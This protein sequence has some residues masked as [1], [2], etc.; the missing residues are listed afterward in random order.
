[1][2]GGFDGYRNIEWRDHNAARN[3]P[4]DVTATRTS[5]DSLFMLAN[6]VLIGMYV[7]IPVERDVLISNFFLKE[8]SNLPGALKLTIGYQPPSGT[9]FVVAAV[10]V[11]KATFE[12]GKTYKMVPV[13]AWS[14]ISVHVVID[15]LPDDTAPSGVFEFDLDGG[16]L[17]TDIIRPSLSHLHGIEVVQ[18]DGSAQLLT[19]I[20]QLKPGTNVRLDASEISTG[21]YEL[22][23]HAIDGEGLS[24][25]CE[26]G[27]VLSDPIRTI[28]KISGDS[29]GNI[30]IVGSKCLT[31][32]PR[33]AFIAMSNPC[34]EPCC[35]CEEA[36]ALTQAL[37]PLSHRTTSVQSSIA[38]L[39]V[40]TDKLNALVDIYNLA[41]SCPAP[42]LPANSTTLPPG[43]TIQCG[44]N[45][46]FSGGVEY[47][48]QLTVDLGTDIGSVLVKLDAYS[49]P[50]LV[51]VKWNGAVVL[52]TG[53]H[54]STVYDFG[55]A[56]RA[57]FT[58]ALIG[59][60]DP[61]YGTTF[62]D[63][64]NYPDD[65]YPRII[66]PT[67]GVSFDKTLAQP[68]TATI[69][70]YAPMTGTLW[71][72]VANCP[73]PSGT[74]TSTTTTA[75]PESLPPFT[76]HV[77]AFNA[78]WQLSPDGSKTYLSMT[79]CDV[80]SLAFDAINSRYYAVYSP[81]ASPN[82]VRVRVL[83]I[84]GRVGDTNQ[85]LYATL[86]D[87][88]LSPTLLKAS[89]AYSSVSQKAY[90]VS[91]GAIVSVKSDYTGVDA[92]YTPTNHIHGGGVVNSLVSVH[93]DR[94]VFV[95]GLSNATQGT[96]YVVDL[97]GA[98]FTVA[99]T[100][101]YTD[102]PVG[103]NFT[104]TVAGLSF[105]EPGGFYAVWDNA[106]PPPGQHVRRKPTN[107]PPGTI[108]GFLSAVMRPV[109]PNIYIA[110]GCNSV[111][112][113]IES[114]QFGTNNYYQ[115]YD[116]FDGGWFSVNF[117]T[118]PS[119]PSMSFTTTT[120]TTAAPTT[121]PAPTT[122]TVAPT[123]TPP[124]G[125]TTTTAAPTTTATP[126]TTTTAAPTTTEPPEPSIQSL[127]ANLIVGGEA[128]VGVFFVGGDKAFMDTEIGEVSERVAFNNNTMRMYVESVHA[129]TAD[130]TIRAYTVTS[131]T[132][133]GLINRTV[134]DDL[135]DPIS[136]T[137]F[138]NLLYSDTA[139]KVMHIRKDRI[140]ELDEVVGTVAF[141]DTLLTMPGGWEIE[142]AGVT[143]Y[144]HTHLL[145]VINDPA[146][147]NSRR[148]VSL[149]VT[150]PLPWEFADFTVLDA[151]APAGIK[152]L[153]GSTSV[154]YYG[155][156]ANITPVNR[157]NY[158]GT[159]RS[160]KSGIKYT[161]VD[162]GPVSGTPYIGSASYMGTSSQVQGFYGTWP[163]GIYR[164]RANVTD[165][166][167]LSLW[168]T[169]VAH[170]TVDANNDL[171][172]LTSTT[173]TLPPPAPLPNV[174]HYV[175]N[176]LVMTFYPATNSIAYFNTTIDVHEKIAVDTANGRVYTMARRAG[177]TDRYIRVFNVGS[178]TA[179]VNTYLATLSH[180]VY[181][182]VLEPA[183]RA[184]IITLEFSTVTGKAY[185]IYKTGVVPI[186]L[187][188]P[189][190]V[191]FGAAALTPTG[192]DTIKA[193]RI[194]GNNLLL[195][196]HSS[197]PGVPPRIAYLDMTTAQPWSWAS[198]TNIV[199]SGIP[200]DIVD[201]DGSITD[202]RYTTS[203]RE[204]G[205]WTSATGVVE[206]A[207][208]P[209]GAGYSSNSV[210]TFTAGPNMHTVFSDI[211]FAS[212]NGINEGNQPESLIAYMD[213]TQPHNFAQIPV[214]MTWGDTAVADSWTTTA[215]STTA[216]PTTTP[217]PGGTT[218]SPPTTTTAPSTTAPPTTTLPPLP[219]FDT[220]YYTDNSSGG[221]LLSISLSAP[222]PSATTPRVLATN[223]G[224][225][226]ASAVDN[227]SACIYVG[228]SDGTVKQFGL[229][230]VLRNQVANFGSI[231]GIVA[232]P[233][234]RR[235]FIVD[236]N[237]INR[238]DNVL[239]AK[240]L[241]ASIP[242]IQCVDPVLLDGR[243]LFVRN[244]AIY[245]ASVTTPTFSASMFISQWPT[246]FQS[247]GESVVGLTHFLDADQYL[248]YDNKEANLDWTI[249]VLTSYGRLYSVTSSS[250]TT[251]S[252][253]NAQDHLYYEL[254]G[255]QTQQVR[256]LP[257]NTSNGGAS[258][259]DPIFT[260]IIATALPHRHVV[261]DNSHLAFFDKA[262]NFIVTRHG[263]VSN[264]LN[265]SLAELPTRQ[266]CPATNVTS[267]SVL[268]HT[269]S[270]GYLVQPPSTNR[271][272]NT[273][274]EYTSMR[275]TGVWPYLV[276]INDASKLVFTTDGWRR[277]FGRALPIHAAKNVSFNR[278]DVTNRKQFY[279]AN[280]AQA[281]GMPH[282][283]IDTDK[284][285]RGPRFI[286]SPSVAQSGNEYERNGILFRS[287]PHSTM[288]YD[289]HAAAYFQTEFEKIWEVDGNVA[290][291]GVDQN[292]I[293]MQ[294]VNTSHRVL[295][296]S[297]DA[298]FNH[299]VARVMT[300][301]TTTDLGIDTEVGFNL[302][303]IVTDIPWSAT[304][305]TETTGSAMRVTDRIMRI[306]AMY[307]LDATGYKQRVRLYYA[308]MFTGGP[309]HMLAN[310]GDTVITFGSADYLWNDMF[311]V[312]NNTAQQGSVGGILTVNAPLQSSLSPNMFQEGNP[313]LSKYPK[314][315]M[316]AGGYRASDVGEPNV[317]MRR[318][319]SPSDS[320][321]IWVQ[322]PWN[323]EIAHPM[324]YETSVKL[325]GDA[326]VDLFF[327]QGRTATSA[328]AASTRAISLRLE[329]SKV[330][331]KY[332]YTI[333]LR[334]FRRQLSDPVIANVGTFFSDAVDPIF[335]TP[336]NW[337]RM[338]VEQNPANGKITCG[339][340]PIGTNLEYKL[341]TDLFN[342]VIRGHEYGIYGIV[343]TAGSTL[344]VSELQATSNPT[345]LGRSLSEYGR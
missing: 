260:K 282:G 239:G 276:N 315:V 123:T 187:T 306:N 261:G 59:R 227:R 293:N 160:Y 63:L 200:Y 203:N 189:S 118:A 178:Q 321:M 23:V 40:A 182:E 151:T 245:S 274:A 298:A 310:A 11:D 302:Y 102:F 195:V 299:R 14:D 312:D 246:S 143:T 4:L 18:N 340:N 170:L 158:F 289:P 258:A 49:V 314:F 180:T 215:P 9:S 46:T 141:G 104:G 216:P 201:I 54:G 236:T 111:P 130:R 6:N 220:L 138:T 135:A 147:F 291:I 301:G 86:G 317:L 309:S 269:P 318:Y 148:L 232:D 271:P 57:D 287:G 61:V 113:G 80:T 15:E 34:S 327:N 145:M 162:R 142:A 136:A 168:D 39:E 139:D 128:N 206:G 262:S 74:T 62:P 124:P 65:G 129:V 265:G 42:E 316:L 120:T 253:P 94:Y 207:P 345:S 221:R 241:V 154:V 259:L 133:P 226:V 323:G 79:D 117:V 273:L 343:K 332:L 31:I 69:E 326:R 250:P 20:I 88:E 173:T 10:T 140:V 184:N 338:W 121:T 333:T 169:H 251:T 66:P 1:M 99:P 204:I 209:T 248:S 153:S 231:K 263:S 166:T 331:A 181:G 190:T 266:I 235:V 16:R 264:Y 272:V 279:F 191:A 53:Y 7:R 319:D 159:W 45:F 281:V 305:D 107:Q 185:Q 297:Q 41:N 146:V 47:P 70:V 71:S 64:V 283:F 101:L 230:G 58:A 214:S 3:Y 268:P 77:G 240:T 256:T 175:R 103:D 308:P 192:G 336:I 344:S 208:W 167:Q 325:Q 300:Y 43:T 296:L 25:E 97:A 28:N 73:V 177:G 183:A 164:S 2:S 156:Q 157:R 44:Q 105:V 335:G 83:D 339:V 188:A 134:F 320:N 172:A 267:M 252:L 295:L 85:Y 132:T 131:I 249:A 35:G 48:R 303:V 212:I 211:G 165:I 277:N 29:E 218:T 228:M 205:R 17:D 90:I 127:T 92:A 243:I 56:S 110:Y 163:F 115:H 217:P 311:V 196:I 78:I 98:A 304:Y 322:R 122:T 60:T 33:E 67:N 222:G 334:D 284:T 197:T 199:T 24:T 224:T 186:D 52:S 270:Y 342:N 242:S 149:D 116:F 234:N 126:T 55:E 26:C 81:S 213:N 84:L 292:L 30:D 329:T 275:R 21:V 27:D 114:V 219:L 119:V 82:T 247:G 91:S 237:G 51:V 109:G 257:P 112:H 280:D 95:E 244:N 324:R 337:V 75:A 313:D 89:I 19:G 193:A 202:I 87:F 161:E 96:L 179:R 229:N 225:A 32:L 36:E 76:I 174:I 8:V 12:Q 255:N 210:L 176:N 285:Y 150:T 307:A 294:I 108:G 68:S 93:D 106:A 72:V 155:R 22:F 233:V 286:N 13:A 328:G 223:I 278:R 38:K 5:V 330:G 288:G 198:L 254:V 171:N 238:C 50:D 144:P 152:E 125:G 37:A 100:V 290:L 341:A 194:T 137:N